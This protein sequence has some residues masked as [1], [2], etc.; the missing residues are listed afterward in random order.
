MI[1]FTEN[2]KGSE[3]LWDLEVWFVD[4]VWDVLKV[5]IAKHS[6]VLCF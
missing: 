3:E 1:P 2:S 5:I 4:P 6:H